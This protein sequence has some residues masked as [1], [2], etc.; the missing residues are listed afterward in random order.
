MK[1]S[2][3]TIFILISIILLA[4]F[5]LLFNLSQ[6][7]AKTKSRKTADMV[8]SDLLQK[9]PITKYI[10]KCIEMSTKTAIVTISKQGGF[11]FK[12]QEG[13]IIDWDIP[14][15]TQEDSRIAYQIYPPN[16]FL[17]ETTSMYPCYTPNAN[18][19]PIMVGDHCYK[20]YDH[21]LS[22]YIFGSTGDPEKGINPDLCEGYNYSR[23]GYDCSCE[24]CTGYSIETQLENFIKKEIR[25]CVNISKLTSYNVSKGN[26]SVDL[27]IGSEDITID[28]KYPLIINVKG[29]DTETK[30]QDFSITLPIR[31]KTVYDTARKIINKEMNDIS[32]HIIDDAYNLRIPYLKYNIYPIMEENAYLY[33]INDTLSQI[34][35]HDY[36]FQFGIKNRQPALNYY[37][38]DN[39]YIDGKYYH[40]CAVE[41]E[42]IMFEPIA[43]DPDDHL[44]F[45][46]YSGWKA[47]YDTIFTTT[48]SNP[49]PHQENIDITT[50]ILHSSSNYQETNRNANLQT[51]HE[52]IGPHTLNL[53]VIDFFGLK[54]TQPVDIMIDDRPTVYFYGQSPYG[55]ISQDVASIEDPF[56]LDASS[57]IDYFESAELLFRWELEDKEFDYSYTNVILEFPLNIGNIN[58]GEKFSQSTGIK[59]V[60]LKTK[61]QTTSLGQT[62]KAI[63]V[64]DCLPHRSNAAAFPFYNY[65][66]DDY[67]DPANNDPLQ[68][69]HT[70]CSDG[71]DGQLYGSIRSGPCYNLIDYGCFF[72]FDSSDPRHIDPA[73]VISSNGFN[74]TI[75]LFSASP[76]KELFRREITVSCSTRGNIC[77]G[78]VQVIVVPTTTICP[79]N[80]AHSL[81]ETNACR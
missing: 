40:L 47:N 62:E 69:N 36:S 28:L 29:F 26:I 13:T 49:T 37:N 71:T 68:A 48:A 35:G 53:T 38:P 52:D 57:T 30:F 43:Y 34:D 22:Y 33:V 54:D 6:N 77:D 80:C 56:T 79:I 17:V 14:Y 2:Q 21:S 19:P 46:K 8:Y 60:I 70:C 7:I 58:T 81:N 66:F 32:F 42:E 72:H 31:L 44:L 25:D 41:G 51:K 74:P 3:V 75:N 65:P 63:E 64:Y 78:L 39:C 11:F 15:I 67:P 50:N 73:G 12:D 16:P 9:T 59:N 4:A 61:S 24:E 20:N 76:V 23:A 1:K 45:Y 55:D 10:E 27:L 5:L 18:F